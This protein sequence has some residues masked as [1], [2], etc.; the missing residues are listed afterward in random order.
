MPKIYSTIR[1]IILVAGILILAVGIWLNVQWFPHHLTTV[2]YVINILPR[3]SLIASCFLASRFSQKTWAVMGLGIFVAF[4]GIVLAFYANFGAAMIVGA[5]TPIRDTAQ[6]EKI[7]AYY[8]EELVAHFPTH[9]PD[10]AT[11][12]TFYYLP[13]FMQGGAHLQLRCK[14]PSFQIDAMLQKY[15]ST[16]KQIQNSTGDI[17]ESSNEQGY[18]PS[19]SFFYEE[20]SETVSIPEDLLVLIL[21]AEPYEPGNWNHGYSCGVAVSTEKQEVIYWAERW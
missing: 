20:N 3:F 5:T 15:L 1:T 7:L 21:D 17:V 14:L 16:A 11:R 18:I 10:D 9:I 6:Y 19:P 12:V 2:F 8:D 4:L 13:P